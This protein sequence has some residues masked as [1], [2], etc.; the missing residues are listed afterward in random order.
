MFTKSFHSFT[1]HDIVTYSQN[2]IFHRNISI[3]LLS[4]NSKCGNENTKVLESRLI[5]N[6]LVMR[7]RR[8]CENCENRFTTFERIEKL[9]LNIIKNNLAIEPYTREKLEESIII[10]CNKRGISTTII[11]QFINQLENSWA[12]KTEIT[13]KEVGEQVLQGLKKIDNEAY[14]RYAPVHLNFRDVYDFMKFIQD[15]FM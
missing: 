3:I 5:E 8:L 2:N 1:C 15:N 6:G 14:V 7:R 9:H 13:S 11:Y 10:S 4:T 12:G